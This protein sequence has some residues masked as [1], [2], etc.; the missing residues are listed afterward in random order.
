GKWVTNSDDDLI[1]GPNTVTFHGSNDSSWLAGGQVGYN[2]QA[3]GSLW[4]FGIEGDGDAQRFN[5]SVVVGAPIG[6]VIPG[7]TLSAES[8]WQAS[9][10][11][12]I[13]YAAW[14]RALLYVTGGVAWTQVKGTVGLVG[15]GPFTDDK[16]VTG[17][18]IGGGLEY[19]WT[20][21]ISLG[22]EGRYTFY[23]H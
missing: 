14:A 23:G 5:K 7:G 18:T 10:R 2:W 19:A 21:N 16:T 3:P 1:A 17:G 4:V 20:D 6:P 13:G 8:N 22:I 9:L 15:I 11:G 12:R